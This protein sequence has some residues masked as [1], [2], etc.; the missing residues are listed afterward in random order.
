MPVELS[1]IIA[2]CDA[3]NSPNLGEMASMLSSLMSSRQPMGSSY[4][5]YV[6]IYFKIFKI[7]ICIIKVD[8][9]D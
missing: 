5:T 7:Y 8:S 2:Y 1:E 6:K 9:C 3:Y 4:R